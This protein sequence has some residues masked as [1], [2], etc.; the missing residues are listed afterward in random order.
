MIDPEVPEAYT[1]GTVLV[2]V[3]CALCPQDA[4]F[5]IQFRKTDNDQ[6]GAVTFAKAN[7]S[8]HE[9]PQHLSHPLCYAFLHFVHAVGESAQTNVEVAHL[10]VRR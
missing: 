6:L 10:S 2:I 3:Q 9:R 4:N 5:V 7:V 8:S 1:P